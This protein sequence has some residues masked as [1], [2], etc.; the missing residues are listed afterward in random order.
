MDTNTLYPE[1][2]LAHHDPA[3]CLARGLFVSLP[4]GQRNRQPLHV[5]YDYNES[6]R[7]EF[8]GA[9][10][11]GSDDL[12]VLVALVAMAT[13]RDD[14]RWEV[15]PQPDTDL[16]QLIRQRMGLD[17]NDDDSPAIVAIQ[18]TFYELAQ[19]V[20][21]PQYSG[22]VQKRL[23]ESLERLIMVNVIAHHH[24]QRYRSL[25]ISDYLTEEHSRRI[26]VG[27][28]L[29]ISEAIA[30]K[31]PYT[32]LAIRDLHQLSSDA[33][34]ILWQHLSGWIDPGTSRR[35]RLATLT[36]YVFDQEHHH[37]LSR[38]TAW[39]RRKTIL[40]A[41]GE[42]HRLNWVVTQVSVVPQDNPLF[43][44]CRSRSEPAEKNAEAQTVLTV[45]KN[46]T[47]G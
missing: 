20:G 10:Q 30:H 45:D 37:V 44:I 7:L 26:I 5:I 24:G 43:E 25:I 33:A 15:Q 42:L 23:R 31:R 39:K 1:R 38:Q 36:D 2:L 18:T 41:L 4:R 8:H 17:Q 46:S 9:Y 35:V 11:L 47:N 28:N 12:K 40:N 22:T 32:S 3:H 14:R 21:Y 27:L 19:L 13:S 16:G 29:R 6:E 34:V